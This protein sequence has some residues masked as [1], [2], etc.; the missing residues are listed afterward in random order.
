MADRSQ[1]ESQEAFVRRILFARRNRMERSAA[2]KVKATIGVA[3]AMMKDGRRPTKKNAVDYC[4]V[5]KVDMWLLSL[6]WALAY[7]GPK[8]TYIM[9]EHLLNR[10]KSPEASWRKIADD[11]DTPRAD[12]MQI[13]YSAIPIF[14]TILEEREISES[15]G[16]IEDFLDSVAA[17]YRCAAREAG[18]KCAVPGIAA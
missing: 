14:V 8:A 12:V 7:V 3:L 2:S 6:A 13:Y 10:E 15:V 4:D 18:D 5:S 17:P 16:N 9:N 1:F 11:I